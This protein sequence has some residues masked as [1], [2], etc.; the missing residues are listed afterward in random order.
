M[1]REICPKTMAA[2]VRSGAI[3]LTDTGEENLYFID[4]FDREFYCKCYP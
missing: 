2:W 3:T 4:E 1:I